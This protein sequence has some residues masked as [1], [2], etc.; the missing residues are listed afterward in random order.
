MTTLWQACEH[1]LEQAHALAD[2]LDPVHYATPHA[3]CFGGTIGGHL[4]H[5]LEHFDCFRAGLGDGFVDYDARKRG[6]PEETDPTAAGERLAS[7]REWF[8]AADEPMERVIQ[9]SVDCG[10]SGPDRWSQSS[11]ARELQFLISH[12]VHHFAIIAVMCAAQGIALPENFGVAP[13]TL[14]YREKLASRA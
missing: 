8:G 11:I 2:R 13:S 1:Y 3:H 4:R 9:V 10:L 12:T 7:L 5:C 6:T 14:K